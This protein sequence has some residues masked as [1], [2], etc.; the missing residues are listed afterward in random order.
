MPG[1]NP[2]AVMWNTH[3]ISVAKAVKKIKKVI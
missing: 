1:E 2:V 3:V